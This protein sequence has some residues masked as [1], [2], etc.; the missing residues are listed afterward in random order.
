MRFR[1]NRPGLGLMTRVRSAKLQ[2][3]RRLT[4]DKVGVPCV[5]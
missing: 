5:I 2:V 4:S 3:H 1:I